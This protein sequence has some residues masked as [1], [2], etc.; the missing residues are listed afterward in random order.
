MHMLCKWRSAETTGFFNFISTHQELLTT[1]L[2]YSCF[3]LWKA[4]GNKVWWHYV[5]V[6]QQFKVCFCLLPAQAYFG[7]KWLNELHTRCLHSF[8][9]D[10]LADFNYSCGLTAH[11]C[12][13]VVSPY[14]LLLARIISCAAKALLAIGKASDSLELLQLS[15]Q[16]LEGVWYR[17][18]RKPCV[19]AYAY[20]CSCA[21][22]SQYDVH[23]F[24]PV[25]LDVP[26]EEF[27]LQDQK[28]KDEQIAGIQVLCISSCVLSFAAFV[29]LWTLLPFLISFRLLQSWT[30]PI[31]LCFLD[32]SSFLRPKSSLASTQTPRPP[33][34]VLCVRRFCY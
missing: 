25:V 8:L 33:F 32:R 1:W 24:Q 10:D 19:P 11:E 18:V 2:Y 16:V 5:S 26:V 23:I 30:F 14:S 15:C 17:I 29:L 22:V 31:Y 21:C 20:A 9:D 4:D 3:S 34:K 7:K 12:R 13:Q 28:E 6:S 27:E